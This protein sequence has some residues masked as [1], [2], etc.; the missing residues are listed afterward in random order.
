LVPM[1]VSAGLTGYSLSQ[2]LMI[3]KRPIEEKPP[4]K[5]AVEPEE[6]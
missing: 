6:G 4:K 3:F 2:W 1:Y 5:K